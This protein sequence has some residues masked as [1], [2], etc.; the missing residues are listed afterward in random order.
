MSQTSYSILLREDEQKKLKDW[1]CKLEDNRADRAILRR[2]GS[3]DDVLLTPAFSRFLKSMPA[4][5]SEPNRIYGS[6]MVAGLLG[7]V[8]QC[9][10]ESFA[11]SLALPRKAGG[12]AMMN[13]LR[14][15]QLQKSRTTDEFFI[16]M[17]RA[18]ALIDGK[19]DVLSVADGV[20]LWLKE[21]RQSL[22]KNPSRRLAVRWAFEY[23]SN[24]ND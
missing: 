6:A 16:R 10:N 5:W 20:L 19:V 11:K 8:K 7:R 9:T 14:F 21:Q 1:Y 12:K 24:T 22:D 23:Y 4:H 2:S 13:E 18:I 15:R 17:S 3:A